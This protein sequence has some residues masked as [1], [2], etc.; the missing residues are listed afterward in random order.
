MFLQ[1]EKNKKG[2]GEKQLVNKVKV[3]TQI[4]TFQANTTFKTLSWYRS[5][6]FSFNNFL[7]FQCIF[8]FLSC[9]CL[10]YLKEKQNFREM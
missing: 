9:Y 7:F 8:Y 3:Y 2:K 6:T 1:E 10:F 5:V 4:S